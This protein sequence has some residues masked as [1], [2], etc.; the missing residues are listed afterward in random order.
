MQ[1][2]TLQIVEIFRQNND[3]EYAKR[4]SAYMKGHFLF[5]GIPKPKRA[6]LSKS[7][8]KEVT[9]EK[10][11][12]WSMVLYLWDLPEREYQ[13]LAL[14][15]LSKLQKYMVKPDVSKLEMLIL[16]K[17]WWDSVD[18][19]APLVGEICKRYPQVKQEVLAD[20]M[21]SSNI[22]LK[23][24]SIIFQLKYKNDVDTEFLSKAIIA[25]HL[26]KEFFVNKAIGWALR[27]YSKYNPDWVRIFISQH[28]LSPL[29]IREGSKYL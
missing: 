23:R 18:A 9:K 29:S 15:Y 19:L 24:V 22:W 12:D 25:N 28:S 11:I 20:W 14:E 17:S 4:M 7:F 10:S 27:Q 8:L 26:S 21:I 2:K 3:P 16:S 1:T 5:L 6:L 13:Y